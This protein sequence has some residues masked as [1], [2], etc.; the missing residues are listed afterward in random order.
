MNKT[1]AT[2][3][4]IL[5]WVCIFVSLVTAM[6]GP[7]RGLPAMQIISAF[8]P[9]TAAT[10]VVVV[11]LFFMLIKAITGQHVETI[12]PLFLPF[13][14]GLTLI[15]THWPSVVV[16]GTLILGWY[17]LKFLESRNEMKSN[18]IPRKAD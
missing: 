5:F 1:I 18:S 3:I 9:Q 12:I 13:L 8:F 2:I 15:G 11:T 6:T 17:I 16:I 14:A 4:G 7:M 10:V